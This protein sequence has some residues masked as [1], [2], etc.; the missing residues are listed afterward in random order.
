LLGIER[1]AKKQNR[2]QTGEKA[3]QVWMQG[4]RANKKPRP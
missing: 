1:S 4:E 2:N 3:D